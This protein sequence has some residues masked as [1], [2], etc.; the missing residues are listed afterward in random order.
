MMCIVPLAGPDLL[1]PTLGLKPLMAVDGRPLVETALTGRPWWRQ[2]RLRPDGLV[3]VLRRDLPVGETLEAVLRQRF[4]GAAFVWLGEL[5]GGA[6]L[7]ALAGT[8]LLRR[9]E[10]PLCIDLVDLLYESVDP[11]EERFA[12]DPALAAVVPWFE[13]NEDCYSY[14]RMDA[15][16]R[17]T[18]AVE[19]RVISSCASA[20]SYLFRDAATWLEAAAHSIRHRDRLGCRGALFV[21]PAMTGLIEAGRSVVGMPVDHVRPITKLFHP[22]G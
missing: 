4:P 10:E 15:A 19:K 11:I 14:L 13:S 21:C 1:H 22:D 18:E 17:V 20:G 3:F 2:G 7:S 16:G 9:P 8:A 12:A 6:L 5:S